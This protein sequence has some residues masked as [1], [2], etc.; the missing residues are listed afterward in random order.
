V[1][2]CVPLIEK[3]R[4]RISPPRTRCAKTLNSSILH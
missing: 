1:V 3:F 2:S 4:A